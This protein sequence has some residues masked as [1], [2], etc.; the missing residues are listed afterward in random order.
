MNTTLSDKITYEGEFSEGTINTLLKKIDAW[1]S[2][3]FK[4]KADVKYAVIELCS[5]IIS[6]HSSTDFGSIIIDPQHS[7][8]YL[9]VSSFASA[10]DYEIVA[11]IL[12][13]LKSVK[14]LKEHYFSKLERAGHAESVQLGMLKTYRCCNGNIE[15]IGKTVA[16][17]ILLTFKLKIDDCN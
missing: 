7:V 8:C 15:L 12:N 17:K 3:L 13:D 5:N 14:D 6:H 1:P 9:E 16:S 11:S 2:S 4:N 10:K